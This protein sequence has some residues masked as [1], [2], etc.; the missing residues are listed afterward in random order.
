MMLAGGCHCGAVRYEAAGEVV[1]ATLCHCGDCRRSSGAPA[2]GWFSV[3]AAALRYT[4]GAPA[5]FRSSPGVLRG[6]CGRC[7]TTLT[8][9]R[10]G[11]PGEVDVTICSLD[12]PD[13]VAPQDHTFAASAV[14][15][16]HLSDGL[17]RYPRS[18]T[19]GLG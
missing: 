4:R 5:E 10:E 17:P 9:R 8:W 1:N 12:D 19:E 7:G 14:R 13:A 3:K 6:F 2:V 11:A 15:W 16:L 18:R